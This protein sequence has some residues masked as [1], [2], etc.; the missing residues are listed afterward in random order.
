MKL[1]KEHLNILSFPI[2]RNVCYSLEFIFPYGLLCV[3]CYCIC[4]ARFTHIMINDLTWKEINPLLST[5]IF[6][7]TKLNF[8]H[9]WNTFTSHSHTWSNIW[10]NICILNIY[11]KLAHTLHIFEVAAKQLK[12][13]T[14][15][16]LM[17]YNHLVV[18]THVLH[19]KVFRVLFLAA[20]VIWIK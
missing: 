11:P 13:Q 14:A 17:F 10:C 2:H 15:K 3:F 8:Q 1:I 7:G 5:L 16:H 20:H 9:T 4:I 12:R 19:N 18:N 6:N